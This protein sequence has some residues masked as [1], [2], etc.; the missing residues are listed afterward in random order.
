MLLY[1]AIRFDWRSGLSPA[2]LAQR[3]VMCAFM[4]FFGAP[5]R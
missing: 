4:V 2:A 1:I 5:S 3:L